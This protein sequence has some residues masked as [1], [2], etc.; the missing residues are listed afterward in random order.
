MSERPFTPT[1]EQRSAITHPLTPLFL[2]A[3]A[4]AGKTSVMAERILWLV[5]EGKARADEILALTFT[6]KAALNL[7]E[8]VRDRLGADADV[9]V[10]TYHSFG[11]MVIADHASSST[12]RP[13]P[14][15]STRPRP[16]SSSTA[17]S[18]SSASTAARRSRRGSCSTTPW[19]WPPAAPTTS[20][21]PT[22]LRPIAS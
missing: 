15:C 17:S 12:W 5:Q 13:A 1:P 16:G 6:N 10:A 11:Q 14:P 19:P 18:T 21:R 7:K 20:V 22:R 9:T 3:G 2:I 4:G 8:K